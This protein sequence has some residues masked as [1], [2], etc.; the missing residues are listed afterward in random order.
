MAE[1]GAVM[2]LKKII[3][4]ALCVGVVMVPC[5]VFAGSATELAPEKPKTEKIPGEFPENFGIRVGMTLAE[6][7]A[8]HKDI[9]HYMEGDT[10]YLAAYPQIQGFDYYSFVPD[11]P[12]AVDK[13]KSQTVNRVRLVFDK[14]S[15]LILMT[16][17]K[18]GYMSDDPASG[19]KLK[20]DSKEM[21]DIFVKQ[22]GQPFAKYVNYPD[23]LIKKYPDI[24]HCLQAQIDTDNEAIKERN[25]ASPEEKKTEKQEG[26]EISD[27]K[28]KTEQKA[29]ASTIKYLYGVDVA[30]DDKP[31]KISKKERSYLDKV[32]ATCVF[33]NRAS[34]NYK[35]EPVG[36]A[37]LDIAP[38][39]NDNAV[40]LYE[41]FSRTA[42][43]R[44]VE[45]MRTLSYGRQ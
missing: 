14:D 25:T 21:F 34:I 6:V 2:M 1:W 23:E 12:L 32:A 16:I 41:I 42:Y 28:I 17:E 7:K 5:G 18:N 22:N 33:R 3:K 27:K 44:Y 36:L 35:G 45:A 8:L 38:N 30:A 26:T 29:V 37:Q 43:R 4:A 40:I 31:I 20:N 11:K 24:F 9:T 10:R 19:V 15:N 13:D 39:S